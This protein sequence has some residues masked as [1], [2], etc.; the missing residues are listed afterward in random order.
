MPVGLTTCNAELP[1]SSHVYVNRLSYLLQ[2]S[3][4]VEVSVFDYMYPMILLIACRSRN[5]VRAFKRLLKKL[6]ACRRPSESQQTL[7]GLAQG[8]MGTLARLQAPN[9]A[10]SAGADRRTAK[11]YRGKVSGRFAVILH[12][13]QEEERPKGECRRHRRHEY[14]TS[15]AKAKQLSAGNIFIHFSATDKQTQSLPVSSVSS[16]SNKGAYKGESRSQLPGHCTE[17]E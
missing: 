7:R 8:A 13:P 14:A 12:T 3:T 10:A 17:K 1:R 11:E 2:A 6:Y 9:W 4:H 16:Y 15:D 5:A